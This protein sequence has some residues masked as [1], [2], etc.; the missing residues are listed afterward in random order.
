MSLQMMYFRNHFHY[1]ATIAAPEQALAGKPKPLF[2]GKYT[3]MNET[4][5]VF[6][7]SLL[8]LQI[9][10][11]K[12][13]LVY[14]LGMLNTAIILADRHCCTSSRH[15]CIHACTSLRMPKAWHSI[16]H[17]HNIGSCD[18]SGRNWIMRMRYCGSLHCIL[19]LYHC[20]MPMN[21]SPVFC[22]CVR[23][24]NFEETSPQT[25]HMKQAQLAN[26]TPLRCFTMTL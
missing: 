22:M 25:R 1:C 24:P 9:M 8:L 4:F 20:E 2:S 26:Y 15:C 11:R 17:N 7:G 21:D 18:R 6:K 13:I 12:G 16:P 5:C 3:H 10:G 23:H 14:M 19:W